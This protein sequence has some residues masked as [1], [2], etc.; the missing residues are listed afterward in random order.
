MLQLAESRGDRG[1]VDSGAEGPGR[2]SQASLGGRFRLRERPP[3]LEQ[4]KQLVGCVGYCCL[5]PKG[6]GQAGL[7][8]GR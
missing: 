5:R 7:W 1:P 8:T 2:T 4:P 3:V 6:R